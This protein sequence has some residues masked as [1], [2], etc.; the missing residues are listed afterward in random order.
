MLSRKVTALG[1]LGTTALASAS[2]N[3][4]RN[5]RNVATCARGTSKKVSMKGKTVLITGASAGI[6]ESC[7][8]KFAELESKL[9]LVG[10][11]KH[12]LEGLK[13]QIL[14][15]F[16][17]TQIHTESMD[18]RNTDAC[19]ALPEKLPAGFK[20]VA[21]RVMQCISHVYVYMGVCLPLSVC[22]PHSN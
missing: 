22:P 3:A 7:A 9:V 6:G 4:Q 13:A 1:L 10:R 16:P 2:Y 19:M 14:Q 15:E 5:E 17:R 21:V 11:R 8:W 20:D 12:L 18:V